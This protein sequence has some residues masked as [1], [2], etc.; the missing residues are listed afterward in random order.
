MLG[1]S[2]SHLELRV[3]G[4]DSPHSPMVTPTDEKSS[5]LRERG[6]EQEEDGRLRRADG[7]EKKRNGT[8]TNGQSKRDG[9]GARRFLDRFL[10]LADKTSCQLAG[11]KRPVQGKTRVY[12]PGDSTWHDV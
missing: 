2:I 7:A 5:L 6:E 1:F 11:E 3:V 9:R 10:D 12:N 8:G 4:A